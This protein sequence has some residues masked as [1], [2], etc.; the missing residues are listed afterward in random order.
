MQRFLTTSR[1]PATSV[2][3]SSMRKSAALSEAQVI[4]RAAK[5]FGAKDPRVTI[6]IGDDA[7]VLHGTLAQHQASTTAAD[8]LI[9]TT[10]VL[11]EG[12][13]FELRLMNLADVGYKALMVNLSDVAA[14]GGAPAYAFA[15]LGVPAKAGIT[16][17]DMLLTGV[18]EASLDGDAALVGGDTVRAPQWLLGFTVLGHLTGRPLQRSGAQ[19]GDII[20][21]S[22]RLGLSQTGLHLLWSGAAAADSQGAVAAHRR[23]RARL[24]L[25]RFLQSTGCA[26]SSIDLSDSL[27]QCLVQ[28]ANASKVG[29]ALDFSGYSFAPE[30]LDFR[31]HLRAWRAGGS[32]AFNLPARWRPEK[33]AARF[34]S[35]ADYILACAEDYQLLFTAPPAASDMLLRDSPEPVTRIGSVLAS[36]RNRRYRDECGR[37][38]K[39]HATG[40]EHL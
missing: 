20:W 36:A 39:L 9:V 6:G 27:S 15:T 7:A 23:P 22:G 38:W 14:M 1:M 29:L 33:K 10:D 3:K 25:G 4:A 30:V 26:T 19:P 21:H 32:G 28:L 12:I 34:A 16:D 35:L 11:V 40:F 31:R 5:A 2:V 18:R 24:E 17:I 8:Q 37:S 13:H